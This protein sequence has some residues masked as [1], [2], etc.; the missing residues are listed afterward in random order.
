MEFLKTQFKQN[1]KFFLYFYSILGFRLFVSFGL[2]IGVALLD[3]LG[4]AMFLPL[5]EMMG[6]GEK[7]AGSLG[8]LNFLLV[9]LN[10]L[11]ISLTI[12]SVLM[13]MLL[14]FILKGIVKFFEGYYK[15]ILQRHFIRKIRFSQI[16]LLTDYNYKSFVL[17]DSGRIQNTVSGEVNKVLGA[18]NGYFFAIQGFIMVIVYTGLAFTV[19]PQ[20]TLLVIIGGILS[21]FL[22]SWIFKKTKAISKK[23]T[24]SNHDFQGLLI[25]KVAFFKYLKA[26]GQMKDFSCKLKDKVIEIEEYLK[27]IGIL[28]SFIN[29]IRE[30]L[31]IMVVVAVIIL[32]INVFGG[33]INLVLLSLL[34][35]Y[36]ALTYMMSLQNYWN[37]FLANHGS[38]ENMQEFLIKLE[39]GKEKKGR[40]VFRGIENEIVL[41][42]V[43]FHYQEAVILNNI[44]FSIKKNHTVALVGESGSGKTT[45]MNLLSG[46]VLPDQGTI[47]IDG[48]SIV[49]LERNTYQKKIGYITQDPVIFDDTVFNNVTFWSEPDDENK[50]KFWKAV[51]KASIFDFV[52]G[53]PNLENTRLGNNGIM[54]S[55]GQKQRFSIARELY[56]EVDLLMMDEAT[57]A[58]DSETEMIIQ[59]QIAQLKGSLTI[60]IIAHRLS[61]VKHADE[62]VFIKKGEIHGIGSFK[63]LQ[64]NTIEFKKLVEIQGF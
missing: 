6:G 49:D 52:K 24:E 20:F 16:D 11:N 28:S 64:E 27:K 63:D 31:V 60:I 9:G 14:F 36:R 1:F 54:V 38:L 58:L 55:G 10:T 35:F 46:L 12:T 39:S 40:E 57:S 25:Q 4:L 34:F 53:L 15:V 43:S 21:N 51:E 32:E 17:D 37:G 41:K 47:T 8:N 23:L 3:G 33:S 13:V 22:Y 42:G 19:N 61:T 26:T 56:K 50:R 44:S 30:P 5:L 2:S 18:Y 29:G 59:D 48:K 45:L 7:S 62:I